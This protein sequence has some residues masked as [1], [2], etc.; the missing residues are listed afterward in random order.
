MH[1]IVD[2]VV[3]DGILPFGYESLTAAIDNHI[4]LNDSEMLVI[5]TTNVGV[6]SRAGHI[7]NVVLPNYVESTTTR[8]IYG[9]AVP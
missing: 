6:D 3:Y 4:P 2:N 5:I 1:Q 8:D 7:V 9:I